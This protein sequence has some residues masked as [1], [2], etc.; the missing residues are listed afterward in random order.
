[1]RLRRPSCLPLS[2]PVFAPIGVQ[3]LLLPFGAPIHL[4]HRIG[5][6]KPRPACVAPP[7]SPPIIKEIEVLSAADGAEGVEQPTEQ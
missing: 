5:R 3:Y 1:M 7:S 4:T 6:P 2:R